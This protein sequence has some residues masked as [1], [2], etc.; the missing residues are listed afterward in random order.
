[1][2]II[3]TQCLCFFL[4]RNGCLITDL[5]GKQPITSLCFTKDGQCILVNSSGNSTIKLFDKSTGELLQEFEGHSHNGD[6]IIDVV[7]DNT[8]Q[9]VLAGSEDGCIYVWSL[10]EASLITKLDHKLGMTVGDGKLIVSSL[11]FHP[12]APYLCSASKGTVYYWGPAED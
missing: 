8:D 6:Y 7:L 4:L 10:V 12:S 11:T 3:S 2:Q 5:V 9:K 1:M